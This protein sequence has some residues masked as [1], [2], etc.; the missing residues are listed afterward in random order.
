MQKPIRIYKNRQAFND[1]IM[2]EIL[3]AKVDKTVK[4]KSIVKLFNDNQLV[5]LN[6]FDKNL[7]AD[8]PDGFIYPE[9]EVLKILNNYLAKEKTDLAFFYN[10]EDYLKV[11]EVIKVEKIKNSD[12]LTLCKVLIGDQHYSMVCGA[13]NVKEGM[14]TIAALDNALLF[15]GTK[16]K[17]G[18]VLGVDSMG[19]L[20]SL[21]ELGLDPQGLAK[22]IVELDDDE[23]VGKSFFEIDWRKY[24]V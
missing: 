14:K 19:M 6:I 4:D 21:K 20:C 1:V 7:F 9:A 17:A 10:K 12:K 13:D 5:G 22:G 2:I 18:Q 15:D 24:N 3:D 16:V 8:Y 11:A 23:L